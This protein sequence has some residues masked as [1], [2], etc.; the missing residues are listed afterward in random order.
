MNSSEL[1]CF[2]PFS[3]TS[4]AAGSSSPNQ[5]AGEGILM[6]LK[7]LIVLAALAS[8][9]A[10]PA[11]A[12]HK[13][14]EARDTMRALGVEAPTGKKLEKLIAKAEK[15]PLGA[16]ANPVRENMPEGEIA[17]LRRLRCAD[18][19]PPAFKRTGNVGEGVYGSIIDLY[20]VTCTGK[21]PVEVHMDMYHDG[22][23]TRTVP[24]FTLAPA[25][26]APG[27]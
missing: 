20:L 7:P 11:A 22:P 13:S 18:G 19:T 27:A 17:Y 6:S 16:R 1:G 4:G 5:I 12:Q 26:P 3:L 25:A 2:D 24:G 9:A 21:A 15:H 8:L 23:E 10:A 14:N